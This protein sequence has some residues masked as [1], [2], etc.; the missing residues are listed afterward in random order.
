MYGMVSRDNNG[1]PLCPPSTCSPWTLPE[2][3]RRTIE[4]CRN[5]MREPPSLLCCRNLGG[6]RSSWRVRRDY[7]RTCSTRSGTVYE[8]VRSELAKAGV[9]T[10]LTDTPEVE[11]HRPTLDRSRMPEQ[12]LT[13]RERTDGSQ[14]R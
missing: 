2:T 9:S 11:E 14:D 13:D 3:V 1:V 8:L 5:Q 4:S 7:V 6:R 12:D 10:D